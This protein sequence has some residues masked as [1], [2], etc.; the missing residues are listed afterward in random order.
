MKKIILV[1]SLLLLPIYLSAQNKPNDLKGTKV[2]EFEFKDIS[3]NIISSKN[4]VNK[5]VVLNFWFVGCAPCLEEIPELNEIYEKYKEN[6]DVI[7]ASITF[8]SQKKVEANS[9]KYNIKYP[10]VTDGKEICNLFKVTG[11]PTNIIIDKRGNYFFNFTGGFSGVGKLIE[12][13]ILKA[14]ETN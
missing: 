1:C 5:I 7:F 8:D 4:T 12:D 14:L 10:V 6:S 3:G 2:Q 13:S 9:S 11:F